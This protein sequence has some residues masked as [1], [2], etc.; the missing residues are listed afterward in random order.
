MESKHIQHCTCSKSSISIM[1]FNDL[2]KWLV[3][4]DCRKAIT[5][6]FEFFR[7]DDIELAGLLFD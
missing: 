7:E 6:S 5:N 1:E 4:S 2:G 3:C